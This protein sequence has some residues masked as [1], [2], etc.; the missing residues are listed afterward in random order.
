MVRSSSNHRGGIVDVDFLLRD[1]STN[2]TASELNKTFTLNTGVPLK[3]GLA[4]YVLVPAVSA[5]D[6]LKVTVRCTTAD[7]KIEVT[8]TDS[9]DGNTTAPFLLVL[10]MPPSG[11]TAWE[12]DLA[13]TGS[14]LDFGAVKVW[15]GLVDNAKVDTD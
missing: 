5:S 9:V 15:I 12:Y 4:L 6:S 13:L 8:H 3:K 7:E 14:A 2:L 1:G 11:G 10:P